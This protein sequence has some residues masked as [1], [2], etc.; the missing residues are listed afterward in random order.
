MNKIMFY[1]NSMHEGGAQRVIKNLAEWFA[2]EDN[3]VSI[4]TS[5][6]DDWEYQTNDN[7]KRL[8]LYNSKQELGNFIK[9]N[10]NLTNK[11][12]KIVQDKNP[13]VLIS[14]MGESNFRAI[15]ACLNSNTKCIVSVRNDPD[16]EYPNIL[17][18]MV[19][20]IL[21]KKADGVVFQTE[22]AKNK[23]PKSIRNKSTIILNPIDE[24]FF[25]TKYDG[26][27]KDIVTVGRLTKQKNHKLLIDAFAAIANE[28][29]DNLIIYGDGE[30]KEELENYIKKINMNGRI[31]I[32]GQI[33]DVANTIKSA[34]LFV[35]SSDYEGL[36]N[37]L[38]E[39]MALGIPC[40]STDCPCGG[41][42]ML[43][44]NKYNGF[45]F[46]V[47]NKDD[48][49][50]IINK[51]LKEK[52]LLEFISNNSKKESSRLFHSNTIYNNWLYYINKIK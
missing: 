22:D 9:R 37:S 14:F 15:L 1:I 32:P 38:M 17:M 40:I 11:L 18:K 49:S 23:F 41:P 20:N 33:R 6:K 16:K 48:L 35:L 36:P 31:F 24:V 45:L 27:R 7:V 3:D 12:K 50:T 28:I 46:S 30:L 51:V 26:E 43:I 2:N 52:S 29:N 8:Y 19:A 42:K 21:Y 34:K 47:D 10:I 39:A 25:N 44:K 5:F 4:I 13:D